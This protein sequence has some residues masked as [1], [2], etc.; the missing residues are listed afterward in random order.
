MPIQPIRSLIQSLA[1]RTNYGLSDSDLPSDDTPSSGPSSEAEKVE[2]K[3]ATKAIPAGLQIW[4]WEVEDRKLWVQEFAP[5]LEKRKAERQEVSAPSLSPA[6]G[7]RVPAFV[8]MFETHAS[9]NR[10]LI[11]LPSFREPCH[12]PRQIRRAAL[13]L[14]QSLPTSEQR[15]LLDGKV[16]ATGKAKTKAKASGDGDGDADAAGAAGDKTASGSKGKGKKKEL[17]EE[18]KKA[19][20]VRSPRLSRDCLAQSADRVETYL[21]A[22]QEKAAAK[23]ARE[24]EKEAKRKEREEKRAVKAEKDAA[25]LTKKEEKARIKAERQAEEDKKSQVSPLVPCLA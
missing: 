25:E 17:T 21:W 6:A 14:F 22:T 19:A 5:R 9:M 8:A 24:A 16:T 1:T 7:P 10:V 3:P 2:T 20:E 13:E 11:S 12:H 23:A 15:D 4:C 18:E